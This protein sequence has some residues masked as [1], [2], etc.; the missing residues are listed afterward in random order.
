MLTYG[1]RGKK[2]IIGE[3]EGSNLNWLE[4]SRKRE[5]IFM[6]V[7]GYKKGEKREKYLENW[8]GSSFVAECWPLECHVYLV[9]IPVFNQSSSLGC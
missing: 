4:K 1:W 6:L 9:I 7:V 3:N 8:C 5:G 2:N